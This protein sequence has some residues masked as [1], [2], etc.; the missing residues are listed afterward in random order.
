M[1]D[2]DAVILENTS[3]T[4]V[5][6]NDKTEKSITIDFPNFDYLGFWHKPKTDAPYVCIEPWTSLP[7]RNGVIEEFTKQ[8]NLVKLAPK[9]VYENKWVVT[10]K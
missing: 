5:I 1:F 4:V 6:K 9:S 3:K 8:E 7:S 2:I 10:I